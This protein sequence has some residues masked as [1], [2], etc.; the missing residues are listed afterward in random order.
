MKLSNCTSE[1]IYSTQG[2][3]QIYFKYLLNKVTNTFNIA[4]KYISIY[5]CCI[6][7]L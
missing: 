3:L 5:H 4:Y 7:F 6:S 2:N 1:Q